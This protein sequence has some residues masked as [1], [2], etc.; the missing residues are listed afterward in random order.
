MK[1]LL[2]KIFIIAPVSVF[3]IGGF[4]VQLGQA[5]FGISELQTGRDVMVGEDK[6][7]EAGLITDPFE[8]PLFGGIH[9]YID[10]IPFIDL[11]ADINI[12]GK[13]YKFNFYNQTIDLE[14]LEESNLREIGP[15]DFAWGG[16]STYLTIRRKVLGLGIP[17]LAKAKLF[18]GGGYNQHSLIPVIDLDLM[19]NFLDG[20]LSKDPTDLSEE[21]LLEKLNENKVELTGYHLQAGLQF[22]VLMLDTF[23]FY[24]HTFAEN[25]V[26]DL[27]SFGSLNFR[28]GIGI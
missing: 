13:G 25:F 1:K 20:D 10:A 4:G 14:D 15:Y 26:A 16:L 22:K 23:L 19:E 2:F 17:L 8:N 18:Y 9:F 7:G 11:E 21:D 5:S 12:I 6:I 28:V 24:R 27:N 3:A